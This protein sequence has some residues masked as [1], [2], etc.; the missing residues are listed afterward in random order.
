M[1]NYIN[2]ALFEK[3]HLIIWNVSEIN[4]S[5]RNKTNFAVNSVAADGLAP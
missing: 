2:T 1:T 4:D 3:Y 5:R